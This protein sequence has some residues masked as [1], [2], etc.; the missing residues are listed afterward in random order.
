MK[1]PASSFP[2]R[3]DLS[4]SLSSLLPS[5]H[6]RPRPTVA[7]LPSQSRHCRTADPIIVF[8]VSTS[9]HRL[10]VSS[11]GAILCRRP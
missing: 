10:P 1:L 11:F 3:P 6:H 8:A 9:P 2:P 4:L 5:P 7:V